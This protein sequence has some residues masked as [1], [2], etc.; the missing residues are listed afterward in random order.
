M[1][2]SSEK[3]ACVYWARLPEHTD[4]FTQGYVGVTSRQ[5]FAEERFQEH[6]R[7]ANRSEYIR[8]HF[9][10]AIKKY[11][12]DKMIVEN[13]IIS[14]EEYCYDLEFKLRPKN[15]IGW[16]MAAGGQRPM[17]LPE[18]YDEE[19]RRKLSEINLGKVHSE[20]TKKKLSEISLYHHSRPEYRKR[21]M[22][23]SNS[24]RV[25]KYP[26]ARF[27]KRFKKSALKAQAVVKIA[28]LVFD[29]YWSDEY[30]TAKDI[31]ESLGFFDGQHRAQVIKL[32][33]YF[34]AGWNPLED[35]DWVKE[36]KTE[37]S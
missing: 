28:D 11:G 1:T 34:R 12:P 13:I 23:I 8:Y 9:G 26:T 16:N 3:V 36:H 6:V 7:E 5:G 19:W 20:D 22:E 4:I 14:T 15:N 25:S 33:R 30:L 32:S 2:G 18:S 37:E 29:T 24:K 27:W 31:A 21:L 10:R 35:E 17:R